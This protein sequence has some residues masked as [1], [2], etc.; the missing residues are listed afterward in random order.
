MGDSG[1]N[2]RGASGDGTTGTATG[3]KS[4]GTGRGVRSVRGE[5][6]AIDRNER[7]RGDGFGRMGGRGMTRKSDHRS[8]WRTQEGR[9]RDGKDEFRRAGC[10][11]Y[12]QTFTD[13]SGDGAPRCTSTRRMRLIGRICLTTDGLKRERASVR[14]SSDASRADSRRDAIST[15]TVAWGRRPRA[16]TSWVLP[17]RSRSVRSR[18]RSRSQVG[19]VGRRAADATET[20]AVLEHR[21]VLDRGRDLAI[22]LVAIH[23]A[24]AR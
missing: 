13:G 2:W 17:R 9:R 16:T 11:T 24:G 8:R 18:S 22:V 20:I 19:L 7:G 14:A 15:M 10:V 12:A 1:W 6:E 21:V 4:T 5:R 3:R 23:L